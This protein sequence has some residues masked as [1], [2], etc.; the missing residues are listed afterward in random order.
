MTDLQTSMAE[1]AVAEVLVEFAAP[2]TA[3]GAVYTARACGVE[4]QDGLWQGWIEFVAADGETLRT[5]RETTQPNRQDT[6]YW[7]TGLSPVYLE[8][9]LGRAMLLEREDAAAGPSRRPVLDAPHAPAQPAE[10]APRGS[11]VT[12]VLN[13]FSV[14]RKGESH[15]RRQLAAFSAWHL[16]NIIHDHELSEQ[17]R[18]SL[19]RLTAAQLI[20]LIVAA[21]RAEV[22]LQTG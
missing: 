10:T 13:P 16:V 3:E 20:E 2:V 12:S 19:E 7:A 6:V 14:Y 18:E 8:G 9:A 22:E 5:A 21:V 17:T 15:L 1:V 4:G 11:S